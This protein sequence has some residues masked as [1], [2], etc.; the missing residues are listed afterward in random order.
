MTAPKLN[1]IPKYLYHGTSTKHLAKIVSEG[2]KTRAKTNVSN[3]CVAP[4][5]DKAV[6]LTRAYGLYYA[7]QA[8]SDKNDNLIILKIGTSTLD[9]NKFTPDEDYLEQATRHTHKDEEIIDRTKMF[10]DI[11][12]TFDNS[13]AID[14]LNNLGNCAYLGDIPAANIVSYIEITKANAGKLIF[15]YGYDPMI[16]LM[17]FK[18]MGARYVTLMEKMFDEPC[19]FGDITEDVHSE[20]FHKGDIQFNPYAV[21]HE[22]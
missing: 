6:Y 3:W 7:L 19:A 13:H 8:A 20:M 16:V 9:A 21:S 15:N 22:G 1:Q 4:S 17:N 14:S 5:S 18:I 2:I 10:R 12:D 11:L